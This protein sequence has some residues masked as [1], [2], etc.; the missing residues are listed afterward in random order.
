MSRFTIMNILFGIAALVLLNIILKQDLTWWALFV[1]VTLWV[2]SVIAGVS[3]IQLNLFLENENEGDA[4]F[5]EIA[6]SFDDAPD[7][8]ILPQILSRLKQHNIETVFF[9]IGSKAEPHAEVLKQI[10]QA[11]HIIGNHSYTHL[12]NFPLMTTASIISELERTNKVIEEA[13]G[14]KAHLFRPPFGV[15]NPR[16]AKAVKKLGMQSV[17]WSLRSFDTTLSVERVKNRL[18]KKLNGGDLILLHDGDVKVLEILDFIIP[19]ALEQGFTFVRPDQLLGIKA[20][21]E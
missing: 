21:E 8:E 11:G 3:S 14:K 4:R 1:I 12:P 10:H 5:N 16:I 15:T 6:L 20:Y 7:T 18:K 2:L 9:I 13:C 19:F 17:G